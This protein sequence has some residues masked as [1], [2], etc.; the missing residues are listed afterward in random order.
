MINWKLIGGFSLFA[1]LISLISGILGGNPFA[2]I[3]LRVLISA[4]LFSALGIGVCFVVKKY[5]LELVGEAELKSDTSLSGGVDIVIG[6]E[7]VITDGERGQ[8]EEA[9]GLEEISPARDD[10][11]EAFQPSEA[12]PVLPS[13]GLLNEDAEG[14]HWETEGAEA[15]NAD[16]D[17]SPAGPASEPDAMDIDSLPDMEQFDSSSFTGKTAPGHNDFTGAKVDE[18]TDNQNPADLAKAVRTFLKKDQE[19]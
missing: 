15:R 6:E 7:D 9:S 2:I 4:L 1:V 13:A 19:G 17:S 8:G 16:I 10:K 12:S 18:L 5:L 11:A 3:L 14:D